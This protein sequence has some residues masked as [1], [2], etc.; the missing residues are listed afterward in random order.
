MISGGY[1]KFFLKKCL[2]MEAMYKY[3]KN[4]MHRYMWLLEVCRQSWVQVSTIWQYYKQ[5]QSARVWHE[6]D[7][8]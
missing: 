6:S 1:A 2:L 3:N 5:V 7:L 4:T 8:I